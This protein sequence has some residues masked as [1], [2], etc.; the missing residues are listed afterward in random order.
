MASDR[1]AKIEII[2]LEEELPLWRTVIDTGSPP[3]EHVS[4]PCV[5]VS[6]KHLWQSQVEN[7]TMLV[8]SLQI[9]CEC[10]E[11]QLLAVFS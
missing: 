8:I 5:C 4:V 7:E 9:F 11:P 6:A 3:G 10:P 2:K 1:Q